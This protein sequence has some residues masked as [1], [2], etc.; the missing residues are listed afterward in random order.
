MHAEF[1]LTGKVISTTTD[2]GANYVAA[3]KRMTANAAEDVEQVG[4]SYF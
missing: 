4:K 1:G 2:N 3:F